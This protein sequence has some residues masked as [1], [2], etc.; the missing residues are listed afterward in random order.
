MATRQLILQKAGFASDAAIGIKA[1]LAA[2]TGRHFDVV[3][4]CHTLTEKETQFLQSKLRER[5]PWARVVCLEQPT[6]SL[7][8]SPAAFLQMVTGG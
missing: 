5:A 4:L 6:R 7:S 1:A 2:F 3:V 8:Y